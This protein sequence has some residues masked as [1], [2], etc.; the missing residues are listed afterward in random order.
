MGSNTLEIRLH[1]YHNLDTGTLHDEWGCYGALIYSI[2]I[3]II[4]FFHGSPSHRSSSPSTSPS[5]ALE[6]EGELRRPAPVGEQR[7][8]ALDSEQDRENHGGL[9]IDNLTLG[10]DNQEK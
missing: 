10:Q 5:F 8:R 6:V 4:P 1:H 2:D 9:L 3:L 7:T